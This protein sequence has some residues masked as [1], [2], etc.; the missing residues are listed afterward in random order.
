MYGAGRPCSNG[1]Q[2]QAT[3]RKRD[4]LTADY[5]DYRITGI[6]ALK[7]VAK[8]IEFNNV[9]ISVIR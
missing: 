7:P 5:T 9:L 6:E 8:S 4:I 1:S 2:P 3:N